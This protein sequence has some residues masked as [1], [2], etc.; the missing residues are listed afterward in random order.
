MEYPGV[1]GVGW[2]SEE[3]AEEEEEAGPMLA[4]WPT[5]QAHHYCLHHHR[6]TVWSWLAAVGGRWSGL[7]AAGGG[8]STAGSWWKGGGRPPHLQGRGHHHC[9]HRVLEMW[10]EAGGETVRR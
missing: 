3:E 5:C 2:C 6:G 4:P 8:G 1:V 9:H 10:A 7:G